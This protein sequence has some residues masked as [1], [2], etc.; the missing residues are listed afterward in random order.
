MTNDF[1][2]YN[3]IYIVYDRKN[4]NLWS[5]LITHYLLLIA[6]KHPP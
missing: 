3:D 5:L 2:F 1:R 6:R 4:E